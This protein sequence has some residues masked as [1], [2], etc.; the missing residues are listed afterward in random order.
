MPSLIASDNGCVPNKRQAI[1]YEH[2]VY[3]TNDIVKSI[4]TIFD[5]DNAFPQ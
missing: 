5:I 4:P 3:I 1:I 2:R